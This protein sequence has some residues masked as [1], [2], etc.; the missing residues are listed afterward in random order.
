MSVKSQGLTLDW[1]GKFGGNG[2]DVVRDFYVDRQGNSYTT[3]YFTDTADFDISVPNEAN[4]ISEGFFDV[5]VQKT[6]SQGNF[7]WAKNIGSADFEYGVAIT[8]DDS[9]NVYITGYYDGTIDCDPGSNQELLTSEG[10]GDIF[11]LKL[12][13][14]GEFVWGKS[15]GG[16]GYEEATAIAT[17][18]N[19]NVIVLG[20]LYEEVDF[21]PSENNYL[22]NTTGISDTFILTLDANGN[23][24]SA[25]T[26]GGTGLDLGLDMKIAVNGDIYITGYFDETSDFDP[27]PLTSFNV[28]PNANGFTSYVLHLNSSGE[29]INI[30]HTLGGDVSSRGIDVDNDGNAYIAGYF[31]GVADFDG[32]PI[33]GTENIYSSTEFYN[34]FLLKINSLGEFVW[35]KHIECNNTLF[36][37]DISVGSTGEVY[38][39]GY[40]DGT[41]D[42]DP[43]AGIFELT[44][45]TLNPTDAFL[46]ALKANGDFR[47]AYTFGGAASLDTHK[48]GIDGNNNVYLSAHFEGEVDIN[49]MADGVINATSLGFR[50]CYLIKMKQENLGIDS[51][52]FNVSVVYPNPSKDILFVQSEKSLSGEKYTIFDNIGKVVETGLISF[53][54]S[55]S[56]S[57]ISEGMYYLQLQDKQRIKFLK[58]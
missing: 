50:D 11:I 40:F 12:N 30:F 2:E 18:A 5:F 16:A 44:K 33:N 10:N 32:N 47:S 36:G 41:A 19:G 37:F 13:S 53:N 54:N 28:T 49:P 46:V 24:N 56:I 42:F 58:Y 35:A 38:A 1:A 20:Y 9:G 22:L 48:M 14:S 17:D 52:D 15:V 43:S 34:G 4:L 23:F 45:S 39:S 21:D 29:F 55:I 57:N 51:P 26:Y 25:K 3:G 8:A 31:S 27:N 7:L 6:D